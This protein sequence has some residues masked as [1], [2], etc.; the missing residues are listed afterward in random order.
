MACL[1]QSTNN[2]QIKIMRKNQLQTAEIFQIVPEAAAADSSM[3]MAAVLSLK[4]LAKPMVLL[5]K[6]LLSPKKCSHGVT[7]SRTM[8]AAIE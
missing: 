6:D 7:N 5:A 3:L 1:I 4:D 2:N 8:A